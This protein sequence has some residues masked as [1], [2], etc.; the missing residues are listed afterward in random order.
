MQP[1]ARSFAK[2]CGKTCN[3]RAATYRNRERVNAERRA[4]YATDP[5]LREKAKA[6]ARAAY[7]KNREAILAKLREKSA[8]RKRR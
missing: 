2:Y 5:E 7:Y 1:D 6:R 4:A 8:A 3:E